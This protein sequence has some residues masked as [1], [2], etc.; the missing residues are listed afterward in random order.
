M[1]LRGAAAWLLCEGACVAGVQRA[2][3][4]PSLR[5]SPQQRSSTARAPP[6]A[7]IEEIRQKI[8]RL[9]V[10]PAFLRRLGP[11]VTKE[12]LG[13]I[14][15]K[16]ES[17]TRIFEKCYFFCVFS[18]KMRQ[19]QADRRRRLRAT[20]RTKR[21]LQMVPRTPRPQPRPRLLA[22][23]VLLGFRLGIRAHVAITHVAWV[24]ESAMARAEARTDGCANDKAS[25]GG[26]AA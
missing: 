19:R 25:G 21:H 7:L 1:V 10:K 17:V 26:R 22:L 24:V 12:E 18:R 4:A 3:G 20:I 16:N 8:R 2:L 6:R 14:Y 15:Q 13:S 23:F 9:G 5:S 11:Y